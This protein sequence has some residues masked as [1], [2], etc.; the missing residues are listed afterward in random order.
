MLFKLRHFHQNIILSILP[1]SYFLLLFLLISEGKQNRGKRHVGDYGEGEEETGYSN[2]MEDEYD[3]DDADDSLKRKKRFVNYENDD[4]KVSK[5]EFDFNGKGKEHGKL[6]SKWPDSSDDDID[7]AW[8]KHKETWGKD[9]EE[10]FNYNA[11]GK[12]DEKF[13]SNWYD[14]SDDDGH[15]DWMKRRTR[16]RS[17]ALSLAQLKYDILIE[18]DIE[19]NEDIEST[20]L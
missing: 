17:R 12:K 16:R 1:K 14:F 5:D 18:E 15:E 20:K 8:M 10:D 4:F 11:K 13:E 6:D 2:G 9:D 19:Y 7:D 3:Y